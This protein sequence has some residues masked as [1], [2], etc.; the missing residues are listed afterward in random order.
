[1][2]VGQAG[3]QAGRPYYIIRR[4]GGARLGEERPRAPGVRESCL[5][6][7]AEPWGAL[8]DEYYAAAG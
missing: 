7:L 5:A 4:R 1:M 3:R 6:A 2:I 8:S